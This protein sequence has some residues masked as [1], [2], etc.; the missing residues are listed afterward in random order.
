R[1]VGFAANSLLDLVNTPG[2]PRMNRRIHIAESPLV[3]RKLSIGMHVPLAE[4]QYQL[5]LCEIGI[6]EC[7]RNAMES[8]IPG[9]IPRVFPLVGHRK[10]V[11]I[12]EVLPF[13]ISSVESSGRRCGLLR[14]T[15][16]PG[17][18]IEMEILL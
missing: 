7:E 13:L 4:H 11:G 18:D 3:G 5:F 1:S 17:T 14:I 15:V 16:Q 9:G 6:D 8:E 10:D 12:I 2:G